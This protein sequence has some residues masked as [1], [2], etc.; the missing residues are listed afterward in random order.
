MIQNQHD[1]MDVYVS[2]SNMGF[3]KVAMQGP[4]ASPY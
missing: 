2:E 4:S 3:W 1:F